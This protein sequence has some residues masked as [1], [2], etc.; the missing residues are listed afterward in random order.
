[1]SNSEI[2]I[3]V[4]DLS[5]KY[6]I[7]SQQEDRLRYALSNLWKDQKTEEIWAL[8]DVSFE[9]KKGEVV[10]IIG[11]N[12]AG[13]STL[14]KIL[15]KITKPTSGRA[16]LYGRVASL[17]EVGTGFHHELTGRENIYLNGNLLGLSRQEIKL[18]FDEIIDFS[19]VEKFIDTPV[20]HY[21]SG[22]YVRLAFSVAAHLNPEILLVDEVLAVGDYEF[23]Q[24][25]LGKM[26][27]VAK[28][29]RTVLL[30]SHNLA[31]LKTLCQSY[32]YFDHGRMMEKSIDFDFQYNVA[33]SN[34]R[35]LLQSV[36]NR[37]FLDTNNDLRLELQRNQSRLELIS[38]III[39]I[40]NSRNEVM[41]KFNTK[42]SINA[43]L[44][45]F[46][47]EKKLEFN[48][49]SV[50][51]Y[52][53]TYSLSYEAYNEKSKIIESNRLATLEVLKKDKWEPQLKEGVRSEYTFIMR[54]K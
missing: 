38:F 27:D 28:S 10:G 49:K 39:Y 33:Q 12:G 50:S 46:S 26:D 32:L 36:N 16:I 23:Q 48:L 15:S 35:A 53:G 24:K 44:L 5:K 7:G 51:L 11:R 20:K 25:C 13:K 1:M 6:T 29:G 37:L 8:R 17:L 52:S 34:S 41:Y 19:G 3:R 40:R 31:A 43:K 2:A 47:S 9:I 42:K 18:R 14:L 4:E 30:V 21:S 45:E 22:M 54:Q